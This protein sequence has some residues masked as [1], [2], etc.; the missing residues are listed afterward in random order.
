MNT[1]EQWFLSPVVPL[2]G[3]GLSAP[4]RRQSDGRPPP[5]DVL[6]TAMYVQDSLC[7]YCEGC[8]QMTEESLDTVMKLQSLC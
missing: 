2:L 1:K 4:G 3:T 8:H 5:P 7:L 6:N